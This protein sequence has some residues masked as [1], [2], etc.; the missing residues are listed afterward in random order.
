MK[1]VVLVGMP[2]S[3]KTTLGKKVAE[4]LGRDFIDLDERTAEKEG[5]SIAEIFLVSGEGYF[6]ECEARC[7]R[8]V[9]RLDNAVL[10]T[11]GGV[12]LRMANVEELKRN[13]YL[14]FIDRSLEK[15]MECADL[16]S[17]PLLKGDR[18]RIHD[19]YEQRIGLYRACADH[20]VLN[21]GSL[22]SSVQQIVD[23][24]GIAEGWK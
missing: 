5:R 2:G 1:N 11:G 20:Q 14:V 15:I 21:N 12:V 10:S 22:E 19:L 23:A 6:R 24:V 7:V 17:R 8:E 16:S 13:G 9:S 18:K 4:A 3:G